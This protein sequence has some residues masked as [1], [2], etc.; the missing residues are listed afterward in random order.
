MGCPSNA[1]FVKQKHLFLLSSFPSFPLFASLFLSLSFS[2][3]FFF[4]PFF[5]SLSLFLSLFF[6]LS[7]PAIWYRFYWNNVSLCF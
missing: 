5:L 2:L 3:S 6:F 1:S 7:F 4:L